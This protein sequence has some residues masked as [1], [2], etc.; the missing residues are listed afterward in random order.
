LWLWP[1]EGCRRSGLGAD[2]AGTE[3]GGLEGAPGGL[4]LAAAAA[5]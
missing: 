2:G 4:E 1:Y 3:G 5:V